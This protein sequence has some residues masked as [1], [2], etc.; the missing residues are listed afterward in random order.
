MAAQQPLHKSRDLLRYPST[1][2]KDGNCRQ[3]IQA[4]TKGCPLSKLPPFAEIFQ[5]IQTICTDIYSLPGDGADENKGIGIQQ[6]GIYQHL[7][8]I[9]TPRRVM[10]GVD[11]HRRQ[12]IQGWVARARGSGTTATGRTVPMETSGASP[13]A[14][15]LYGSL[16]GEHIT[17][18]VHQDK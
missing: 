8:S 16:V 4:E 17:A 7:R 1:N 13:L 3:E 12:S 9:L 18:L 14:A 15:L 5:R 6:C 2:H 11:L 10:A